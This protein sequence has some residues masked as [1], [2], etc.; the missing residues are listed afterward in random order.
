VVEGETGS[1]VAGDDEA[2]VLGSIERLL[3]EDARR[4]RMGEAAQRRVRQHGTWAARVDDFLAVLDAAHV[5]H[6]ARRA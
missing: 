5:A 2:A 3:S 1:V 6:R 4:R